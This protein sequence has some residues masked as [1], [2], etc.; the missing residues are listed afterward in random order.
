VVSEFGATGYDNP[1]LPA[2]GFGP[3]KVLA[4]A[5]MLAHAAA[6]CGSS[7]VTSRIDHLA[8]RLAPLVRS[9]R[10]LADVALQ[11]SRAFKYAVPHVLLSWL[12]HPDPGADR[13]FRAACERACALWQ[14][15][16]PSAGL[17]RAWLARLWPLD[18]ADTAA[19]DRPAFACPLDVLSANREDA[20][21]FTH[22]LFYL[23]DFGRRPGIEPG[24]PF[25]ELAAD[26]DAL[27]LRYLDAEDYDLVGELLMTWPELGLPWSASATFAF[28]VLA[29]VEDEVGVLPCGNVDVERFNLLTG[30]ERTR[31]AQ[32]TGYHTA[33][34]M[35]FLCAVALR[36]GLR[37][38]LTIAAPTWTATSRW[39]PVEPDQGHW[40]G[41]LL[42]S[43]RA[44]QQALTPALADLALIQALRH[45][46]Y[47][48][49]GALLE[50]AD[51]ECERRPL[52]RSARARVR[53]LTLAMQLA[54]SA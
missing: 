49:L 38:P 32:A 3:E 8:I 11:P 14:D 40:F 44:E 31:Y 15:L 18:G 16:P 1:D 50:A 6:G 41:D 33:F 17:E 20:Y 48:R 53:S 37:P 26:V 43:T 47:P 45:N 22:Q 13:L 12:G 25:E 42:A 24:R 35:G 29:R 36:T 21:A 23:T 51:E 9:G 54:G 34:V 52:W 19:L 10:A 5:T 2:L 27:V 4:E 7:A 39:M 46:D 30:V 28:R